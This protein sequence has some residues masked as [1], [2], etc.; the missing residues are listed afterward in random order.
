MLCFCM[1]FLLVVL[2][3]AHADDEIINSTLP[4]TAASRCIDKL[5]SVQLFT[6][7]P[8]P[9]YLVRC[10]EVVVPANGSMVVEV[11]TYSCDHAG[12]ELSGETTRT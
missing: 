4:D 3:S 1:H 7:P 6:P 2:S 9:P 11:N 8:P 10:P 5:G 12:Y